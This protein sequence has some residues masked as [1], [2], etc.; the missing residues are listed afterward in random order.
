VTDKKTQTSRDPGGA[1]Q[2]AGRLTMAATHLGEVRDLPARSLDAL[3]EADLLVFEED[4]PA[5]SFLKAAGVHRDYLRLSEHRDETTIAAVTAA[6]R[7]GKWVVYMSDQ[8]T[9]G[10]SDPGR[11]LVDL[12]FRLGAKVQ[13]IPGPSSITA[14][15]AACPFDC[16]AFHFLGFLPRED[17][18]RAAALQAAAAFHRPVIL[19]D[20]P[21]RL[22]HVLQSG[23]AVFGGTRRGFVALDVSGPAEE[24]WLGSFG[25]LAARAARLEGKL[26]FVLIIEGAN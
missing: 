16:A 24:Y 11:E 20:T 26:N 13:V 19:M 23:N 10:L 7:A 15:V 22:K 14:A 1:G 12:A 18:H 3:R 21:Y 6:L 8:G 4:R 5:R 25:E 9:P 2:A 17:R